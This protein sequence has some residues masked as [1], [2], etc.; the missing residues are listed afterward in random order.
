M[1]YKNK[2]LK[3]KMKYLELKTNMKGGAI[4]INNDPNI[5]D[6]MFESN[7]NIICNRKPNIYSTEF[8]T[9]SDIQSYIYKLPFNDSVNRKGSSTKLILE[10][11]SYIKNFKNYELFERFLVRKWIKPTD[12]VLE[13][14]GR[15]GVISCTINSILDDA[16]KTQHVVVEPDNSVLRALNK[17]KTITGSKFIIC[18]NPISSI[19]LYLHKMRDGLGNRTSKSE[20]LEI[21]EI[22]VEPID[23][24]K[25]IDFNIKYPQIFNVLVA[26]CEGCLCEFIKENSKIYNNLELLII[27]IDD[28]INCD[29]EKL[30]TEKLINDFNLIDNI[31]TRN[32]IKVFKNFQ[33]VWCRKT[34]IVNPDAKIPGDLL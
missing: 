32:N 28:R 21:D 26:D 4:Y 15:L 9:K 7:N 16:H 11:G 29:Y 6:S 34:N 3:Y 10:N 33:Q 20:I 30:I 8:T 18:E 22:S 1:D 17:N 25:P 19:P 27:E 5:E 12:I 23:I 24:I 13:L 14:G 31:R 2:Y